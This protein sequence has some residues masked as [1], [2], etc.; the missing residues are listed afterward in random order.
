MVG[1]ASKSV[2]HR[3]DADYVRAFRVSQRMLT[4]SL[5][6]WEKAAAAEAE[7]RA[8]KQHAGRIEARGFANDLLIAASC[9]AIGATLITY[10]VADF[11][12]IGSVIGLRFTTELS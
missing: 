12:P 3:L 10:N 4:P 6:I 1:A 5:A 8:R 9:R 11:E 2:R 7:L